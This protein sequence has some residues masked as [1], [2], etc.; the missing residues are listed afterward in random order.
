MQGPLDREIAASGPLPTSRPS[1]PARTTRWVV[2]SIIARTAEATAR[3]C[4]RWAGLGLDSAAR[5]AE[6]FLA[7][8]RSQSGYNP[9]RHAPIVLA[10]A[11]LLSP[12][13]ATNVEAAVIKVTA[14][15]VV[16]HGVDGAGVFGQAGSDLVGEAYSAVFNIDTSKA[17]MTGGIESFLGAEPR[18]YSSELHSLGG[19]PPI[20]ASLT[21]GSG[22]V[23]VDGSKLATNLYNADLHDDLNELYQEVASDDA[24]LNLFDG[25][26]LVYPVAPGGQGGDFYDPN[27]NPTNLAFSSFGANYSLGNF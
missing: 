11:A 9:M 8:A 16:N 4:T 12:I 7:R 17:Y 23:L 3:V 24:D 21:I 18:Y 26:N 22:S 20:N 19:T 2:I 13:V 5:C 1:D 25:F 15:G 14:S 27:L 6:V 10:A